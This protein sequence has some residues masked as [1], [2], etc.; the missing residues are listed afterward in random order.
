M[1][2][3]LKIP[4]Q[5]SKENLEIIWNYQNQYSNVFRVC[6]NNC[7]KF[8]KLI[9]K[10][11]RDNVK[12]LN[13]IELID[14]WWLMN[15]VGDAIGYHESIRSRKDGKIIFGGKSNFIKRCKN[16]ITNKELKD[17]RLRKI[18]SCRRKTSKRK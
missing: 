14:S 17:F 5:T 16:K 4:Y 8:E 18:I 11:Q 12:D 2:Q 3:T 6:F 15:S 1:F 7:Y 10:E 13:N 9:Q